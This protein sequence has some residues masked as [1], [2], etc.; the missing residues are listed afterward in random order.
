MVCCS[1]LRFE[2]S[3]SA[4][5]VAAY[6]RARCDAAAYFMNFDTPSGALG[7]R[8]GGRA[9]AFGFV[10]EQDLTDCAGEI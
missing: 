10:G 1:S 9:I 3:F 8:A 4:A 7:H 2:I 5:S 6:A